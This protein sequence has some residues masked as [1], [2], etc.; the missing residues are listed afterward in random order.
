MRPS[1]KKS[2][3]PNAGRTGG[4]PKASILPGAQALFTPLH[5]QTGEKLI[6]LGGRI[7][8][9]GDEFV[10]VAVSAAAGLDGVPTKKVPTL[11]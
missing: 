4:F 8:Q 11:R 10:N 2:T 3:S 1:R 5:P 9:G 6:P 7:I